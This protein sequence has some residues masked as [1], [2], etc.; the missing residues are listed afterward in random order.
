MRGSQ[1]S[2]GFCYQETR[3]MILKHWFDDSDYVIKCISYFLNELNS[4]FEKCRFDAA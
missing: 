4:I 3:S 2:L 1:F